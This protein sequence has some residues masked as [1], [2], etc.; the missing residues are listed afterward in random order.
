MLTVRTFSFLL[1]AF[2]ITLTKAQDCDEIRA[3]LQELENG[4]N[5]DN[6]ET[7]HDFGLALLVVSNKTACISSEIG[8]TWGNYYLRASELGVY[9]ATVEYGYYKYSGS[10]GLPSNSE[11]AMALFYRGIEQANL[12]SDDEVLDRNAWMAAAMYCF[13]T[14]DDESFSEYRDLENTKKIYS[15]YLKKFNWEGNLGDKNINMAVKVTDY[16]DI[17]KGKAYQYGYFGE[18]VNNFSAIE[19]YMGVHKDEAFK[20]LFALFSDNMS[21]VKNK[22]MALMAYA[23]YLDD[24]YDDDEF[25]DESVNMFN[26]LYRSIGS[27]DNFKKILESSSDELKHV[28][29]DWEENEADFWERISE[30]DYLENEGYVGWKYMPQSEKNELWETAQDEDGGMTNEEKFSVYKSMYSSDDFRSIELLANAY[31]YG[32]GVIENNKKA[33]EL[34]LEAYEKKGSLEGALMYAYC[35]DFGYGGSKDWYEAAKYYQ[36]AKSYNGYAQ[37]MLA[38]FYLFGLGGIEKDEAM[39]VKLFEEAKTNG[40]TKAAISLDVMNYL[41]EN[42]S[43]SEDINGAVELD[44]KFSESERGTYDLSV[45]KNWGYKIHYSV[46]EHVGKLQLF[47]TTKDANGEWI[48]GAAGFTNYSPSGLY[49]GDG[50]QIVS[51]GN[52][53]Q[54]RVVG[55]MCVQVILDQKWIDTI[56]IPMMVSWTSD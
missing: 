32:K 15:K 41:A 49:S 12:M 50:E 39:A 27:L 2:T 7:I 24:M 20:E 30:S 21:P 23:Y 10:F 56:K 14:L 13:M 40:D 46:S 34:Y 26:N 55:Y 8:Q 48:S 52:K 17:V 6:P 36:I 33:R 43:M 51:I 16:L 9:E 45:G 29:F 42:S 22:A 54:K 53:T 35:C 11:D 44:I 38:E 31:L 4:M 37:R 18:Q 1:L 3:E 28:F 5:E 47:P 25:W 19:S